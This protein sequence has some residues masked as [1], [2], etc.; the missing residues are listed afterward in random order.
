MILE[1]LKVTYWPFKM[2]K[3]K[4]L[5]AHH[6]IEAR[7]TTKDWWA[8]ADA[9]WVVLIVSRR[10]RRCSTEEASDSRGADGTRTRTRPT[11]NSST[12]THPPP[13]PS[14]SPPHHV[15]R[16]TLPIYLNCVRC[17]VAKMFLN[18]RIHPVRVFVCPSVWSV[19][20]ICLSLS[21]SFFMPWTSKKIPKC[22]G[23]NL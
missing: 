17:C 2:K 11:L 4:K 12:P 6:V 14:P 23:I 13:R 22:A 7:K 9:S 1:A 10:R 15:Y 19:S 5:D 3:K 21:P 18:Q 8:T 20:F 16:K